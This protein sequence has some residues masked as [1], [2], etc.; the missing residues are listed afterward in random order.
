MAWIIDLNKEKDRKKFPAI[1]FI[2]KNR[3]IICE[4]FGRERTTK[5]Q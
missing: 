4:V 2:H 3:K 5:E 1:A